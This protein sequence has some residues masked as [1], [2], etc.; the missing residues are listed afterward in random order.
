[1]IV[2][3]HNS[4]LI[5]SNVGSEFCSSTAEVLGCRVHSF[6]RVCL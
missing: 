3:S 5:E 4:S 6:T 1:L 2:N